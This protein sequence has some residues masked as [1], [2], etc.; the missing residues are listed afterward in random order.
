MVIERRGVAES[1][2]IRRKSFA[3]QI[4]SEGINAGGRGGDSSRSKRRDVGEKPNYSIP[5]KKSESSNMVV[6]SLPRTRIRGKVQA[7]KG[8]RS[9]PTNRI[10]KTEVA[11]SHLTYRGD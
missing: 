1:S 3:R 4:E 8:R 7:A 9:R 5:H 2:G 6:R 11:N 10:E